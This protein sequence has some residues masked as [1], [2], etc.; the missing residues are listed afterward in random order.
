MAYQAEFRNENNGDRST[1]MEAKTSAWHNWHRK[2]TL[3]AN[4]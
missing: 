4:R 1:E 3:D 2:Y